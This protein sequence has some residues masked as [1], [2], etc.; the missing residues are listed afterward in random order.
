VKLFKFPGAGGAGF[1]GARRPARKTVLKSQNK[2]G[3]SDADLM[4]FMQ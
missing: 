3:F 1:P 4:Y 2:E